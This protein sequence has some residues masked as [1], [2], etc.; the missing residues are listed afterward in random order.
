MTLQALFGPIARVSGQGKAARQV[1]DL[2]KRLRAEQ[3]Q[4]T[5]VTSSGIDHLLLIDRGVDLLS[6]LA[7]QLTYEGLIDEVF[8]VNNSEYY[9]VL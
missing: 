4:Q 2:L 5:E 9:I 1:I 8:G 7:T 6:P 3:G